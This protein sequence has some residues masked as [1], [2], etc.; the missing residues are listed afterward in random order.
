MGK[1]HIYNCKASRER[2]RAREHTHTR[3][4]ELNGLAGG[5]GEKEEAEQPNGHRSKGRTRWY[6]E[7]MKHTHSHTYAQSEKFVHQP[8]KKKGII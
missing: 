5:R 3:K 4:R 7:I 2:E 8:N 6:K 1:A